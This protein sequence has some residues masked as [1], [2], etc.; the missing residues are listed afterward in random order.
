MATPA[1]SIVFNRA[2]VG[3]EA[4]GTPGTAATVTK[5]LVASGIRFSPNIP[6]TPF[7][8][9]G[10]RFG[11]VSPTQKEFSEGTLQDGPINLAGD[12]VYW[13][14]SL[15]KR[16]TAPTSEV[17]TFDPTT[18]DPN[19]IAT[20]TLERGT[21]STGQK[22][23]YVVC[24]GLSFTFS[25]EVSN[26]SGTLFG[27]KMA[28]NQTITTSGVTATPI[29]LAQP[30][31]TTIKIGTSIGGL[32]KITDCL[33]ANIGITGAY[34]PQ[35]YLNET[36]RE[37]GNI[38]ALAPSITAGIVVENSTN[39]NAYLANY[40]AGDLL[41]AEFTAFSAQ[42]GP[43]TGTLPYK[44]VIQFPFQFNADELADQEDLDTASLTMMPVHD[45]TFGGAIKITVTNTLA[46]L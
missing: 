6:V 5:K 40:R 25:R 17:W 32:T 30:G 15:L 28:V 22:F 12:I 7:R 45:E 42:L 29:A 16:V 9:Q 3:L 11:I 46:G 43:S 39:A 14:A 38:K 23:L 37:F 4:N 33:S 1:R 20:Y 8:A 18:Y 26:V 31:N 13:L 2:Q 19:D 36:D 44:M 41:F 34:A 35:F 10:S 27:R 24:S 21:G